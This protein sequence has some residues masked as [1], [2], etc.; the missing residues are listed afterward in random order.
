VIRFCLLGSGSSGNALLVSSNGSTILIDAGLSFKQLQARASAIGWSLGDVQAVFVTHE[1]GDHVSGLGI[2]ARKLQVP[3]Y[4]T[5]ATYDALPDAVG[6][7]PTATLIEAGDAVQVGGLSV[8]SFSIPHDA[9]DPVSYVVQAGGV[10]LGM[11][12][13]LGSTSDLVRQRLAGSHGLILESNYCPAMLQR[14]PYPAMVQQRIRGRHGHLSN[15][16][17]AALL[18]RLAHDALQVV[19]LVHI[20]DDNN[21]PALAYETAARAVGRRPVTL[22]VARKGSPTPVFEIVP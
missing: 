6:P 14:G 7:V 19:V 18:K 16:D 1:H 12:A 5:E 20:S 9:A 3:V 2:L 4:L 22:H 17:M 8:A 11:A 13:D 10:K 15:H 21:T